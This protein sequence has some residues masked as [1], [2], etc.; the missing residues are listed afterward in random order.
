MAIRSDNG[1]LS[2]VVSTQSSYAF[3]R[4]SGS[5]CD[6]RKGGGI[7]NSLPFGPLLLASSVH[8][9]AAPDVTSS[10]RAR[11]QFTCCDELPQG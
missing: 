3:L 4:C 2:R 1:A 9:S 11:R 5:Y 8:Q 10:A 7:G 6:R